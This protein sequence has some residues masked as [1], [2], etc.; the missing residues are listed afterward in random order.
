V[1][2]KADDT[3]DDDSA[4]FTLRMVPEEGGVREGMAMMMSILCGFFMGYQLV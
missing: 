3:E 2:E 1:V 4:D